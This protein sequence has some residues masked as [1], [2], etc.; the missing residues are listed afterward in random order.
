MFYTFLWHFKPIP[1]CN[2]LSQKTFRRSASRYWK[3]TH[4]AQCKLC[5][6][7]SLHFTANHCC[8]L[9]TIQYIQWTWAV[10]YIAHSTQYTA[11]IT[12]CTVHST[13]YTVHSTHY[14][15][16][17][18]KKS[19]QWGEGVQ[20]AP[21]TKLRAGESLC[22]TLHGPA[23]NPWER[24]SYAFLWVTFT[25]W[26]LCRAIKF[27]LLFKIKRKMSIYVSK[28]SLTEKSLLRKTLEKVN[29]IILD[30]D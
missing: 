29:T 19:T 20:V 10:E 5:K 14:T 12:Q 24:T 8:V 15:R 17:S 13:Q 11:H 16:N 9:S 3:G 1:S 27:G 26:H 30:L 7:K 28:T 21:T 23:C 25:N 4:C 6:K 18:I 2:I 22:T